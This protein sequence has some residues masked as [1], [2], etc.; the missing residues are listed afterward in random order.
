MTCGTFRFLGFLGL[1]FATARRPVVI[2]AEDPDRT[3]ALRAEIARHDELYFRHAAPE[4]TDASYDALRA[5]LDR[6]GPD[7]TAAPQARFGD[8]RSGR[9]PHFRHGERMLSLDKCHSESDLRRFIARVAR[10][11]DDENVACIVEPKYDG[12]AISLTYEQ[13][14]LVRAV[15][16]GNGIDGDDVTEHL[17]AIRDLPP[18]LRATTDDGKTN[19]IPDRIELRG[20]IYL[21]REEFARLNRE[22]EAAGEMPY[23]HPRNVAAGALH[24]PDPEEVTH[25]GLAVVLY[26]WG[27]CEP[28]SARPETQGS[29][30]QRIRDWGLPGVGFSAEVRGADEAW[31]AVQD[32]GRQ[33]ASFAAPTDGVVVKVNAV[34]VQHFA[35]ASAHAPRWATAYKFPAE[36]AKARVERI[37]LQVGRT[38]ALTPVANITPVRL[39]GASVARVSLANRREIERLDLREGDWVTVQRGGEVIPGIVDIDRTRR[40][41]D[42]KP[43]VFPESCPECHAAISATAAEAVLRCPNRDCPAQIRRRVQFFASEVC[44]GI[45][46]LGPATI[47]ALVASGQVKRVSDLY[48]LTRETLMLD[49][50]KLAAGDGAERLLA[51]IEASKTAELWRFV[52]GLGIPQV[53]AATARALAQR[54]EGLD[55]LVAACSAASSDA[56]PLAGMG[57]AT[58][59]SLRSFFAEPENRALVHELARLGVHPT[60]AASPGGLEQGEKTPAARPAREISGQVRVQAAD[61]IGT[62]GQPEAERPPVGPILGLGATP[63]LGCVASPAGRGVPS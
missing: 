7:D 10:Q 15:T 44:V 29:F 24:Q 63:G 4:I 27:A 20:E 46:G 28:S 36:Q 53:G 31:A 54:V 41:A 60:A 6:L 35:G 48:R 49:V 45:K 61:R 16:R 55:S 2:A 40:P 50:P 23:S 30:H 51:A 38:G 18:T 43:F 59:R 21:P 34:S 56:A 25:R 8:D 14:R 32:F 39:G 3:A 58:V 5:E 1:A 22:R 62:T 33:R 42:A 9:L 37:V 47:G 52:L 11:A 12:V 13:G 17:R 57:P 26:G 19:L